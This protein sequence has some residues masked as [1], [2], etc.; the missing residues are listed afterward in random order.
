[1]LGPIAG[2]RLKTPFYYGWLV[3]GITALGSFVSTSVGGLVL[4]GTQSFIPEEMRWRRSTIGLAVT[5]GVWC[6]GLIS[7]VVGRLTDRYGARWL[8]PFGAACLSISLYFISRVGAVWQ[9]YL[10]V[11]IGR[12]VSQPILTGVVPRAI[13]VNFFRRRRNVALSLTGISRPIS[14]A[15]NIQLI[16]LVALAYGWRAAFRYLGFASLALIVV[17]FL[18]IRRRPEDIGLLPDGARQA[19]PSA[20]G[21]SEA[22]RAAK[23]SAPSAGN[24]VVYTDGQEISWTTLEALHTRAFWMLAIAALLGVMGSSGLAFNMVPYFREVSGLS[25]ALAAGVLSLSTFLSLANLG[26]A[27]L[28]DRFTPKW[29]L[30][31]AMVAAAGSVVYLTEVDS[32]RSAYVFGVV[33]GIAVGSLDVLVYMM[34]ADYF[35]RAS[36]ATIVGTFRTFEAVGLG[37]GHSIGAVIY[38]VTG[39]YSALIGL[40]LALYLLTALLIILCRPPAAPQPVAPASVAIP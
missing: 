40:L 27:F 3:L 13:A 20:S 19:Q 23:A 8:M 39:S 32:V 4:G 36:Y 14:A 31:A 26:W 30:A 24:D 11:I 1:V 21:P 2:W 35:G 34:L 28:A 29:C 22:S 18:F 25:T 5:V 6:S 38:D 9:F 12:A 7:P 17:F 16:S 10:I 15:L 37:I 33:W